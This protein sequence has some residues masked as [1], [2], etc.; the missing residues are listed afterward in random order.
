MSQAVKITLTAEERRFLIDLV[1]WSIKNGLEG[2]GRPP[3]GAIPPPPE[4]IL[5]EPMGAFVTLHKNGKLRGCIG[6]MQPITPLYQ[7]V[8]AMAHAAAFEDGR[9]KPLASGELPDIKFDISILGPVSLCPDIKQI[10]LG[11]HGVILKA[12][13][14]SSVFL[15]QVPVEQ[16]W[17][18]TDTLEQL[19]RKA[20]LPP[21]SWQDSTAAVHWY[22]SLLIVPEE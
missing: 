5:R 14:R 1:P 4:G 8:A 19:C 15:P 11:R 17:S 22:E 10:E 20:G 6:M 12:R 21:E 18:L 3:A 16:G 2:R 13:G 7:T 9:F